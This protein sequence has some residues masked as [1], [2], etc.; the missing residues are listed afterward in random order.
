MSPPVSS[1]TRIRPSSRPASSPASD[2]ISTM[3]RLRIAFT[4]GTPAGLQSSARRLSS[5][6]SRQRP[7]VDEDPGRRS[8]RAG[9]RTRRRGRA[10]GPR[11]M[12]SNVTS[13]ASAGR[14][15]SSRTTAWFAIA[16]HHSSI[17]PAARGPLDRLVEQR[18]RRL[19]VVAPAADHRERRRPRG[20]PRARRP[21]RRPGSPRAPRRPARSASR[22]A[23]AIIRS[24]ASRARIRARSTDGSCGRDVRGAPQG[25]RRA[26][27]RRRR[28]SGTGR[29][30]P[31]GPRAAAGRCAGRG[32]RGRSPRRRPRGSG[33][34]RRTRPRR[35]AG[36]GRPRRRGSR[37]RPAV[38]PASRRRLG[39]PGPRRP[40]GPGA[41]RSSPSS[42]TA[43]ASCGA[44]RAIASRPASIAAGARLVQAMGPAPERAPPPPGV[45][46]KARASAAW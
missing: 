15:S 28:P 16:R 24:W 41:G 44:S 12:P 22:N 35:R 40:P 31:R 18:Q 36:S 30:A 13:T 10:S 14:P 42:S 8:R 25:G 2:S 19:R 17:R 5:R 37:A 29:A 23:P 7:D 11:F 3:T 32:R 21:G 1:S 9:C 34:P 33:G 45:S 43:S 20:S 38:A 6:A 46:A 39:T 27:R 4:N 26:R